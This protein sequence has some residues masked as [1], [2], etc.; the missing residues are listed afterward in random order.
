MDTLDIPEFE[1]RMNRIAIAHETVVERLRAY[2]RFEG[3][4]SPTT[5]AAVY[6]NVRWARTQYHTV[7]KP[8]SLTAGDLKLWNE[9]FNLK[10]QLQEA[11]SGN[12]RATKK[13]E[14]DFSR[15]RWYTLKHREKS[16]AILALMRER[17]VYRLKDIKEL[18]KNIEE[19]PVA[20]LSDGTL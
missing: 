19:S 7:L 4:F 20:A 9:F 11:H 2:V 17:G 12:K 6:A 15:T 16:D 1:K 14:K 18:M 10:L 3:E 5:I 8:S 13:F